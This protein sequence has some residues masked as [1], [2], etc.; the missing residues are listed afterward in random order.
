MA[1]VLDIEGGI[2]TNINN[3]TSA[4]SSTLIGGS[5]DDN[6]L[7]VQGAGTILTNASNVVIGYDFSKNSLV[8]TNGASLP[9][10]Y[11]LLIGFNGGSNNAL[12]IASATATVAQS[13]W[14]GYQGSKNG[15]LLVTGSNASLN[16]SNGFYIGDGS[17]GNKLTVSAGATLVTAGGA[18]LGVDSVGNAPG[19]NN[20]A[21]I[22]GI[23][24]TW[25]N[26]GGMIV[27][28]KG[29]GTLT[30]GSGAAVTS[31]TITIAAHSSNGVVSSGTL[32]V[33]VVGGGSTNVS[34]NATTINFGDG[35]GALNFNQSDT[36]Q[37]NADLVS[38]TGKA[39]LNMN[40]SGT[41]ILNGNN[42]TYNGD[43]NISGG[44]LMVGTNGTNGIFGPGG[45]VTLT[46][47]G[48]LLI[49][50]DHDYQYT[51]SNNIS[52]HG[53]LE[54]IGG[55]HLILTGNNDYAG[56]TLIHSVLCQ[57]AAIQI[58]DGGTNGTLGT[59]TLIMQANTNS[60]TNYFPTLGFDLSKNYTVT[61]TLVV[62]L[63]YLRNEGTGTTTLGGTVLL[64]DPSLTNGG[65][66]SVDKGGMIVTGTLNGG[67]N[68][69]IDVGTTNASVT[70]TFAG[71]STTTMNSM[72]IGNGTLAGSNVVTANHAVINLSGVLTV[73]GV[74]NPGGNLMDISNGSTVTST[75][76]WVG[77]ESD[78]N[79]LVVSGTNTKITVVGTPVGIYI[80]D[81][82]NGNS[83]LISNGASVTTIGQAYIGT[84]TGFG[85]DTNPGLD[86]SVVVT[87]NNSTWSNTGTIIVGDSGSGTLTVENGGTVSADHGITLANSSNSVGTL[88]LGNGT[89]TTPSVTFGSGS[90][91]INFNPTTQTALT[92]SIT[93]LGSANFL[94]SGSTT[95]SGNNTYTGTTTITGGTVVAASTNA[96][97]NSSVILNGSSTLSLKAD[98]TITSEFTWNS[99]AQVA[100]KPGSGF[101]LIATGGVILS[102]GGLHIFNLTG[103]KIGKTPMPLFSYGTNDFAASQFGVSGQPTNVT[104]F[105]NHD[106]VYVE[107]TNAPTPTPTPKPTPSPIPSPTPSYTEYA[108]NANQYQ[109][110]KALDG[111]VGAGGDKS[112]IVAALDNLTPSQYSQ[113][114]AAIMPTLYQSLSSIAFNM[115]NSQNN[116][117]IERMSGIRTSE[118]GD[119]VTGI[120]ENAPTIQNNGQ[121]SIP[122]RS[123]LNSHWG[124]FTDLNGIYSQ[125]NSGNMLPNYNVMS[126]GGL[127]GPV[128]HWNPNFSTGIYA[129]YEGSYV[130]YGGGS[131]LKDNSVRFGLFGTYAPGGGKGF[132]VDALAGGGYHNYQVTRAI[133]F[134]GVSR[135][136]NSSPGAGELDAL[137]AGG[138]DFHKGQWTFGPLASGQYTYFAA[139][140]VNETGAQSL[141]FNSSGWQTSSFISNLGVHVNY[142]WQAT[143]NIIVVPQINLSWQHE[144]LQNPYDINGSLGG[145]SQFANT[146]QAPL[147]D[148]LYTGIGFTVNLYKKWNTALFYNASLGNSD[149]VSQ[150][151]FWSVEMRF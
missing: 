86:E 116:D 57:C 146:T 118:N 143:Q 5:S 130:N 67:T 40:G 121:S 10:G 134:P 69:Y 55:G 60:G 149:L 16:V 119:S 99:S 113:A 147:R 54:N 63:G 73:G 137:L 43:V 92:S 95:I 151:L 85:G 14:V 41:T 103:D 4:Y 7:N 80:G 144:F 132:Y 70:M 47:N 104:I 139:N 58:G 145:G 17:S 123:G 97:G 79:H 82:G 88:N 110:A 81:S 78:S 8:V 109:V 115:A 71:S 141:D 120:P 12:T 91:T 112:V 2:T 3:G 20:S 93:G 61:N 35:N 53:D 52:G 124:M 26:S 23:G 19:S 59:G 22:T 32:N 15:S 21:L 29:G 38:G 24:S 128:Y 39:T 51:M 131:N 45:K 31:D 84:A 11:Q 83:M 13:L 34:L 101:E 46:N 74:N 77:A 127:A 96:L 136:A 9:V 1:Q 140:D 135:T 49:N 138:Y 50:I 108:Q 66:V 100:I 33:G 30:L 37:V 129:G 62:G 125:Q 114:F 65:V 105:T 150:S 94:G 36:T 48:A 98:L 72:I 102:G 126:G 27:G 87:G 107:N 90:G 75:N 117:F 44:S 76:L 142:F 42:V 148:S 122:L 68:G 89:L 56:I 111:F 28:S 6:T 106:I 25:S 18:A 64:F 133:N